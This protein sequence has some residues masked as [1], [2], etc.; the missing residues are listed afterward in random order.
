MRP[1]APDR[2]KIPRTAQRACM[3]W[4]RGI[5]DIAATLRHDWFAPRSLGDAAGTGPPDGHGRSKDREPGH[6]EVRVGRRD[7]RDEQELAIAPPDQPA[8]DHQGEAQHC[9]DHVRE[10]DDAVPSDP[11]LADYLVKE[12]SPE[13]WIEGEA[14]RDD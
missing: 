5:A 8:A 7:A 14:H 12:R 3:P 11:G 2:M 4:E 6:G 10:R 13:V 9:A 1:A